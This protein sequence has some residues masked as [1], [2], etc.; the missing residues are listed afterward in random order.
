M[1]AIVAML[2]VILLSAN[3]LA[4]VA[5]IA[6]IVI[7]PQPARITQAKVIVAGKSDRRELTTDDEGFFQSNIQ[8]GWYVI[9]VSHYGF[10]TRKLKLYLKP[11]VVT[12]LN[13]TL[14]L[15]ASNARRVRSVSNDV[16]DQ[17]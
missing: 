16:R 8:P 12:P 2:F 13:V 5:K 4:Q 10:Q 7:D 17:G 1:K 9:T 15:R 6:G 11:D 14:T 3:A